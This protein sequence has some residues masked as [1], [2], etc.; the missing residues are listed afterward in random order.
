MAVSQF[1]PHMCSHFPGVSVWESI[2]AQQHTQKAPFILWYH[3]NWHKWQS[4]SYWK[5]ADLEAVMQKPFFIFII[6][7]FLIVWVS[8]SSWQT[9]WANI[10]H[11]LIAHQP[12]SEE[13]QAWSWLLCR[14]AYTRK[15][16]AFPWVVSLLC[17]LFRHCHSLVTWPGLWGGWKDCG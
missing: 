6:N 3:V 14:N 5:A 1:T 17:V 15:T 11:L 9:L 8:L 12:A 13:E 16:Q 4:T 2:N 7:L 10:D